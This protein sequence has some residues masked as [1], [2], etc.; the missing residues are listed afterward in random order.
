MD[1][2]PVSVTRSWERTLG[3]ETGGNVTERRSGSVN[4]EQDCLQQQ[5]LPHSHFQF[6][7]F[8]L[9]CLPPRTEITAEAVTDWCSM[10]QPWQGYF[11]IPVECSRSVWRA[12]SQT[13]EIVPPQVAVYIVTA[14]LA[15]FYPERI[16]RS[17]LPPHLTTFR[18]QKSVTLV[19]WH[20][21][22]NIIMTLFNFFFSSGGKE[23]IWQR[24]WEVLLSSGEASQFFI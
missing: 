2:R 1:H 11:K 23:T 22:P 5:Q 14:I 3:G 13:D 8:F 7:S 20:R 9:L 18:Y 15:L 6:I 19:S 21:W 16:I 4:T 24:D 12:H 17:S 10:Y